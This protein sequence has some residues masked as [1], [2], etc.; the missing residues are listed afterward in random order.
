MAFSLMVRIQAFLEDQGYKG[1]NW[2]A[3]KQS[4]PESKGTSLFKP[5]LNVLRGNFQKDIKDLSLLM[6]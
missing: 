5:M 2:S 3:N 1:L 4:G 6:R